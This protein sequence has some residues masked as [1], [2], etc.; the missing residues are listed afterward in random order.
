MSWAPALDRLLEPSTLYSATE[1]LIRLI[2]LVI[3][4]M[5]RTPAAARSWLLLLFFQP[6]PGLLLFWL[7]GRPR[8]PRWRAERFARLQPFFADLAA[9][10]AA[11]PA[12]AANAEVAAL[13]LRLGALP[14][15]AGNGLTL[16]D[17]YD[18][19]VAR[20]VADIAAAR[21]SVHILV[22]IFAD[23]A[24]GR[25]VIAALADAVARGL[26][27]R[28]LFDPVGSHPW[29]RGTLAALRAAGVEAREALPVSLFRARTRRDMRNHRKLFVID[30]TIGYVGSQNIVSKDFRPG[31]VNR[32]I[33]VR[34]TGPVV[35]EM[36]AVFQA[37]WFCETE[38]LLEPQPP[39]P[40]PA[41]EATLQLLPSGAD[42]PLEGFETLLVWQI[43]AARRR[44]II[45]TP[46]LVPDD[47]LIGALRTARARGVEIDL[48]VSAVVDQW[49]VHLAQC[50]YYDEILSAGVRIHRYRDR[51]LHAKS[52][53]IDDAL[54]IVG[55]SNVDLRSFQLNEEVSLLLHDRASIGALV[56]VQQSYIAGSDPLDPAAW[57]RRPRLR[58]LAEN[59]ARLLGPLL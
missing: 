18:A 8:F 47:D 41:G 39:I 44:A 59:L 40:P 30:G 17:D 22:Y 19:A 56:A 5:R 4:P 14:A 11:A 16:I 55:S 21:H 54:G 52:V 53:A 24:T 7:I 42:Y 20:L 49:L 13:A 12:P 27:V 36:A 32:D 37:D 25:R 57:R 46:Y 35:A 43:H 15:V 10:L 6:I 1:W 3:V 51:L 38:A 34:V 28:V 29:R 26:A 50:S 23:D 58:I 2:V 48:I 33:A 45:V 31:I 9:R